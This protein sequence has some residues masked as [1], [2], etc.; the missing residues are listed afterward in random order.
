[1]LWHF[2]PKMARK[3]AKMRN[4]GEN[5]GQMG[6]QG[7]GIVCAMIRFWR[8]AA[9]IDFKAVGSELFVGE[10]RKIRKIRKTIKIRKTLNESKKSEKSKSWKVYVQEEEGGGGE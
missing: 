7:G 9:F 3:S 8:L 6:S 5:E 4:I 10:I 2:G 1:M